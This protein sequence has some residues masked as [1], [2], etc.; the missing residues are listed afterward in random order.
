MYL[1]VLLKE[2]LFKGEI[3]YGLIGAGMDASVPLS[4]H[5]L[6][7]ATIYISTSSSL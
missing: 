3:K 1:E 7:D 4:S 2:H 5:N 6:Q